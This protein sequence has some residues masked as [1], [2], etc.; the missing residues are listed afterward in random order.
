MS[1]SLTT[2]H[3]A[4]SAVDTMAPA[5]S[6]TVTSA[7]SAAATTL[8][9]FGSRAEERLDLALGRTIITTTTT[10]T[11]TAFTTTSGL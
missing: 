5:A 3:L 8:H 7:A 6:A 10:T 2:R 4:A 9:R 1:P 11:T